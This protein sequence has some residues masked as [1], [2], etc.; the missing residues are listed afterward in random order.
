MCCCFGLHVTPKSPCPLPAKAAAEQSTHAWGG[1][2]MRTRPCGEPRPVVP[3][4]A[5]RGRS[6]AVRGEAR[7]A[8]LSRGL[9][10]LSGAKHTARPRMLGAAG[11]YQGRFLM[12]LA[13]AQQTPPSARRHSVLRNV[14]AARQRAVA[15]SSMRFFQVIYPVS[16]ELEMTSWFH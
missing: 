1:A 2:P 8:R 10:L 7:A 5:P 9:L 14:K 15:H 4:R 11:S 16:Y 13:L 6:E 12:T 3:R